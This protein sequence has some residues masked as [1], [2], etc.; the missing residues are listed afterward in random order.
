MSDGDDQLARTLEALDLLLSDMGMERSAVLDL[1]KL[2]YEAC[3]SEATVKDLLAGKRLP[4]VDFREVV[5]G[6]IVFLMDTRRKTTTDASGAEREQPYTA[7]EIAKGV[8]RTS[9]WLSKLLKTKSTP[10]LETASMLCRFF[11]VP[12][13]LLM[14]WPEETLARVLREQVLVD[15]ETRRCRPNHA[16]VPSQA[17]KLAVRLGDTRLAR[18]QEDALNVF[19]DSIKA[20]LS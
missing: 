10:G 6:K 20:S 15:L 12:S 4:E 5:F 18:D 2:S 11:N 13:S 14:E 16:D 1:R 3:L 17:M 19:I 7:A 8:G 9:A